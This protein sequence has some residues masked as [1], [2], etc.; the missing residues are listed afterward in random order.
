MEPLNAQF[1]WN[2][3]SQQTILKIWKQNMNFMRFSVQK[4][5][6]DRTWILSNP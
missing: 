5:D 3:R 2:E 1:T 4:Y 6:E